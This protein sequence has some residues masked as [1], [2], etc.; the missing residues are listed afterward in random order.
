[1]LYLAEKSG[2][3]ESVDGMELHIGPRAVPREDA[4]GG[5]AEAALIERAPVTFIFSSIFFRSSWKYKERA[6]RYCLL[7]AGHLA[8][9]TT[10]SAPALH[11]GSVAIGR[12]DD[13]AVNS[14]LELDAGAEGALILLPV[15]RPLN[16]SPP[17]QSQNGFISQPRELEGKS[18]QL[19]RLMHGNT[20]LQLSG[21]EIRPEAPAR[22]HDKAYA[23]IER[24]PIVW[25]NLSAE[26]HG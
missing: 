9:Q 1:M 22:P 26:S 11:L 8:I 24:F 13:G 25:C 3:T 10:L 19:V 4:M 23:G 20:Y 2:G 6:Y 17:E 16:S 15:G 21:Q 14:L 18:H 12:F 5:D 7:D